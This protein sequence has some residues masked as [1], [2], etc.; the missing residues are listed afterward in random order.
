MIKHALYTRK[1]KSVVA[2]ISDTELLIIYIP[3]IYPAPPIHPRVFSWPQI[4]N[5]KSLFL[6]A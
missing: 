6:E 4:R 3:Q 1:Q 5:A 2:P